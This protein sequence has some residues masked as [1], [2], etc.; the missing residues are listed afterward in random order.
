MSGKSK[1]IEMNVFGFDAPKAKGLGDVIESVT[2]AIGLQPCEGCTKRKDWLNVVFPFH[3][4]RKLTQIEIE[5]YKAL[6]ATIQEYTELDFNILYQIYNQAWNTAVNYC[7]PC[8]GMNAI[9]F[10]KVRKLYNNQLNNQ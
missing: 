4:V 8:S 2:A 1:K 7:K 3:R 9:V 5:D 6:P 10:D